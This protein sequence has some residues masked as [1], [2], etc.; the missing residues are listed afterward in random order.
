V[1][2]GE[3]NWRD[4]EAFLAKDDRAVLPTGSTEQHAQLSL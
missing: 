3:M 1:K 4:V 2:I